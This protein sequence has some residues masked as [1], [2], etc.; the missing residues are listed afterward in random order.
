MRDGAGGQG[1]VADNAPVTDHDERTRC[2]VAAKRAHQLVETALDDDAISTFP[3][4][5]RHYRF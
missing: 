5:L 1:V 3:P 2:T 4:N